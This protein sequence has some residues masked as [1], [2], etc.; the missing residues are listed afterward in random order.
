MKL[1]KR[2]RKDE[3]GVAVIEM[4]FALPVL[5]MLIWMVVQLGLVFRAMSGIQHALGEG[6]RA[7]TLWPVPDTATVKAK[8]N[9]AV[10]GIKPGTF[11]IPTP[12][13][14]KADGSDYLD[15]QVTYSQKTDLIFIPG[16][17]ITVSR[18]KRVWKAES[19]T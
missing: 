11:T 12:T 10:Y 16:P 19:D 2:L 9:A 8:M 18:S 5:I 15:L 4:A 7:A 14:G 3:R 13:A 1:F 17:T 6:A